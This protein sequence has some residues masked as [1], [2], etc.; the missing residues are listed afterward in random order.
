MEIFGRGLK[1]RLRMAMMA[2]VMVMT[3]IK[4]FTLLKFYLLPEQM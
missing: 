4:R 1:K 3:I 2:M